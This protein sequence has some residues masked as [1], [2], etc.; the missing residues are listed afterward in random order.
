L[1]TFGLI[2]MKG[3]VYDPKVGLFLSPDKFIQ[4][5][6]H[7]ANLNRYSYVL[8]NPLRYTDPS[9]HFFESVARDVSR[10]FRS[11]GKALMDPVRYLDR[12]FDKLGRG[13]S[14]PRYQRLMAS[15][16]ISALATVYSPF[17]AP[18]L[19][20]QSASYYAAVGATSS[21]IAT[22]GDTQAALQGAIT[23]ATFNLV[24]SAFDLAA[25][26]S[27]LSGSMMAAKIGAHGIVGGMSSEM[28]GGKFETGF[29]TSGLSE[30]ASLGG[31]YGDLGAG[32]SAWEIS[33]QTTMAAVVGGGISEVA[34]GSFE[35]GALRASMG[36][37]FNY[38][39]HAGLAA[40]PELAVLGESLSGLFAL[41][42]QVARALGTVTLSG[43]ATLGGVAVGLLYSESTGTGADGHW[44]T[45]KEDEKEFKAPGIPSEA[46]GFVPA[47]KWDGSS[48]VRANNGRGYGY[49]AKDGSVWVPTGT[50]PSIAHGGPHWDVQYPDGT[51]ENKYPGGKSRGGTK[52]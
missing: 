29:L 34:G 52:K 35:E 46:D 1:E 33:R 16:A 38:G 19:W 2:H 8:N 43:A 18:E 13:L 30:A 40:I 28:A 49:P 51:Y 10:G 12:T 41:P 48:K 27:R 31:F 14:D 17:K 26:G 32:S 15:V 5:P 9:G 45:Y 3:R 24:G 23:G 6:R 50:N 37:L 20:A 39:A 47:K 22:G 4:D 44:S 7:I 11:A 21:Y 42:G 25:G 36:Y